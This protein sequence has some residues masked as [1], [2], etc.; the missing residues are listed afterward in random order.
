[1]KAEVRI[2]LARQIEKIRLANEGANSRLLVM[3]GVL[4][5]AVFAVS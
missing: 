2:G 1:M 4:A 3:F 5:A